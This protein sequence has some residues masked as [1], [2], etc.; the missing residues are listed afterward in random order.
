MM[1]VVVVVVI[2]P[3]PEQVVTHTPH[4]GVAPA[5][6]PPV[7]ELL[8]DPW[9]A[10]TITSTPD[11]KLGLG[12]L[13]CDVTVSLELGVPVVTVIVLFWSA[14]VQVLGGVSCIPTIC[15]EHVLVWFWL[16]TG[17]DVVLLKTNVVAVTSKHCVPLVAVKPVWVDVDVLAL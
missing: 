1:V 3:V 17:V 14:V 12:K 16:A 4:P 5:T 10:G 7:D 9:L 2:V 13:F 6:Q 11:T 15:T 8:L